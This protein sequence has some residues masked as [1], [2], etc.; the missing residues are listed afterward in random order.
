M[1]RS[2]RLLPCLSLVAL[3][4]GLACGP[5]TKGDKGNEGADVAAAAIDATTLETVVLALSDDA[6]QGRGP[7]TDGDVMARDYIVDYLRDLGLQPGMP[8][9]SWEQPIEMIGITSHPEE[10][11]TFAQDDGDER[12]DLVFWDEFIAASGVQAEHISIENAEIVFVGYGITA[13]EEDWDDFKG[14]DLSGKMLLMLNNDP[15]WDPDLFAGDRRLYYGRWTYK[16]E[17]AGRHGAAGAII[18]H[19]DASAGYPFQVVQTGWTGEQFE[20]PAGDEPRSRVAAWTTEAA[21]RRLVA[22]GGHDLDALRE[23]AR[24]RDFKPVPLGV[25]TS[26]AFENT[27]RPGSITANVLGL[28]PGRDSELRNELVVYTA[29]HDHMG[30]GEPDDSG[31][32]IYNGARDNASGVAT[33]LAVATAFSALPE[34]PRRS[35]LFLLV[36]AEEQG[37]LGSKWYAA[38]PTVHPGM[39]TANLNFDSAAIF[40]AA[41]DVAVI[42]RGKSGLEDVLEQIAA[43]EG[44]VVVDEHFPDKGYYYRSDQ[45]NFAKIGVPALYFK[46]GTEFPGHDAEWGRDAENRWRAERYHQPSDEVYDAWDFEGMAEDA[47]LAFRVGLAVAEMDDPPGW[48]P[49]DE[50][51]AV[52]E[53]MEAEVARR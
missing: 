37:L 47:R 7:S 13:P 8:D 18:I 35:I 39:I 5:G 28:L 43:A 23:A 48:K 1:N 32:R 44:R 11:W 29:H 14:A 53:R 16:Y 21:A 36:G 20:L 34:P 50:F 33:V 52:R 26:I 25:S 51:E 9:G 4:S 10:I 24:S 19:T 41:R 6:M 45:F 2:V 31:D 27:L 38:N 22:L 46:G 30:V 49:G 15:D 12:L 42:G 17:S 3:L 40:G